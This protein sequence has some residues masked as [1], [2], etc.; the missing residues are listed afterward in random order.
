M[1][2]TISGGKPLTPERIMQMGFGYAPP[3]MLHAATRFQV[4]D[5]LDAGPKTA[6]EI[7]RATGASERGMRILL[8][9]LVGLELLVKQSDGRYTLTPESS[10]FLVSTKPGYRGAFFRHATDLMLKWMQLTEIVRTGKPLAAVNQQ[11]SGVE[12]FESFVE[13][14]FPMSYGVAQL[15]ADA[16]KVPQATGPVRVLDLAAG[17]GVWGIG[18]AH[19]SPKV[20]VTAV[21]WPGVIAVTRRMAARHG[22]EERMQFIEGDLLD[23]PFGD[24]YQIAT[25]GH[26][27][28]SEGEERSR[29]LFKKTLDALA[30]GGTIA[31]AE[32]LVNEDRTGPAFPL[33]FAVNMLVNTEQGDTYSFQELRDWLEQAGFK[34]VRTLEVPAPSPLVLATKP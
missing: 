8:N 13:S 23:V 30:A 18:I 14:L 12:F 17:S 32:W 10:A 31:I 1:A 24:G 6:A 21:D 16:L 5:Q 25:L 2:S 9:G 19:R 26:I 28:H 20:Q 27:V 7:S 33:I 15:L 11:D 4:F 34:D 29:K 22:V 3:L